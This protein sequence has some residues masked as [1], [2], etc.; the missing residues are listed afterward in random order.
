MPGGAHLTEWPSV[1]AGARVGN[2]K[3]LLQP[4]GVFNLWSLFWYNRRTVVPVVPT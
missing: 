3:A 4:V 2:E 1:R